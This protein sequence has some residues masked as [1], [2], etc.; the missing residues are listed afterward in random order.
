MASF[1]D[2]IAAL[3]S[4]VWPPRKASASTCLLL[5]SRPMNGRGRLWAVVGLVGGF[6]AS[7][8][9]AL[10][11]PA[12]RAQ[13]AV[14][15]VVVEGELDSEVRERIDE[16]VGQALEGETYRL[17]RARAPG[18]RCA[19]AACIHGIAEAN[20][21]RYVIVPAVGTVVQD[22][23]I[24]VR[25]Y[26]VAGQLAASKETTCEICSHDEVVSSIGEQA[27]QLGESVARLVENP[28]GDRAP[29]RREDLGPA[30]LW[31]QTLPSGADV[32]VDGT[33][34]GKTPLRVEVE[35]G[36]RNLE[37]E[38]RGY[39]P[40]SKTVRGTSGQTTELRLELV[41]SGDDV[42]R[43]VAITGWTLGAAALPLL[44]AGI[45]L[46]V[47]DGRP[48][49]G[50]CDEGNIDYEGNCRYV[51]DTMAG[52][53]VLTS[54]GV[55]TALTSVS[56]AIVYYGRKRGREKTTRLPDEVGLDLQPWMGKFSGFRVG[57]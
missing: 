10:A 44:G 26:D 36:L 41:E 18:G 24:A 35:P 28:Y 21:A 53:A 13:V 22:Y 3:E 54:L 19:D 39:Y 15:P 6:V 52:G 56:M 42:D 16:R 8:M 23:A 33:S 46:L 31:V 55:A 43:A 34:L 37:I 48:Y 20:K 7:P 17:V 47:L 11:G 38:R 9:D 57:F 2:M 30:E 12:A 25:L 27:Q 45:T 4:T 5:A 1:L 51:Y 40:V 29:E 49:K 14:L 32:R 50:S